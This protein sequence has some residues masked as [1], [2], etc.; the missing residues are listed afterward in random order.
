MQLEQRYLLFFIPHI[1]MPTLPT[2]QQDCQQQ[3]HPEMRSGLQCSGSTV[4]KFNH[5]L[6]EARNLG[7]TPGV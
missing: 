5:S 4:F 1:F 2:M 6:Q 3:F 7:Q